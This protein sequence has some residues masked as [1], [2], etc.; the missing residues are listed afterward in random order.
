M[1]KTKSECPFL[2]C[3]YTR[4]WSCPFYLVLQN[5]YMSGFVPLR[6]KHAWDQVLG[7]GIRLF[8][9]WWFLTDTWKSIQKIE[10][11]INEKFHQKLIPDRNQSFCFISYGNYAFRWKETVVYLLIYLWPSTEFSI[12]FEPA[13]FPYVKNGFIPKHHIKRTERKWALLAPYH[14]ANSQL[15][16]SF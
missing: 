7:T 9:R 3:W 12:Y 1:F 14:Q 8:I 4:V 11:W 10:D 13:V 16:C 5:S 2:L 6:D 15:N